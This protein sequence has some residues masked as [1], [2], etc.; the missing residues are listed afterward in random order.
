[1]PFLHHKGNN[2]SKQ[3]VYKNYFQASIGKVSS[4]E[5]WNYFGFQ[6]E[7]PQIEEDYLS[8]VECFDEEFLEIVDSLKN[9][10]SL[11]ILSNDVW[12]W[13]RQLLEKFDLMKYF[14]H[15][16]ISGDIGLRKPERKIYL[17]LLQKLDCKGEECVFVD[18]RL[19]NLKTAA[20]LGIKTIRF[21]RK[22]KK[23]PFCSEFEVSNFKELECVID[24]FY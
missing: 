19:N 20:D 13:S 3:L 4:K 9:N 12:E 22:D 23:T 15:I 21:I 7:F 5:L 8:T 6:G 17:H 2:I 16:L 18:D 14:D 1:M 11:A 24:R 10:Y